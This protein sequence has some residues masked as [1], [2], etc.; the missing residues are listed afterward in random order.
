M[1][2]ITGVRGLVPT[3]V[4]AGLLCLPEARDS[5]KELAGFR[6]VS[7]RGGFQVPETFLLR[8]TCRLPFTDFL[9]IQSEEDCAMSGI[10]A[11]D[12]AVHPE[13][14]RSQLHGIKKSSVTYS[15]SD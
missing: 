7:G 10:A 11:R 6:L 8:L 13:L 2:L 5:T 9:A 1:E 15:V 12:L 14:S 3:D 4:L